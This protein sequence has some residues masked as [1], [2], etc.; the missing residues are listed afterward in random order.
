MDSKMI[1]PKMEIKQLCRFVYSDAS[2]YGY[3]DLSQLR[4]EFFQ[5]DK[6]DVFRCTDRHRKQKG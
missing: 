4:I 1:Y 3:V 6:K 5:A 2:F